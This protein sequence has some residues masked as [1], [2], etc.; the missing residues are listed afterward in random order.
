MTRYTFLVLIALGST[1]TAFAAVTPGELAV[2]TSA[3]N[4]TI[5]EK[6]QAFPMF[7]PL[8]FEDCVTDDCSG[9]PD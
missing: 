9:L 5:I 6:N 3:R 7:A 4:V 2:D 8:I 1:V